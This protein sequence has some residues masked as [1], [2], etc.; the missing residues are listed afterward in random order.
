MEASEALGLVVESPEGLET[1]VEEG[2]KAE[3]GPEAGMWRVE[4]LR[5]SKGQEG[6]VPFGLCIEGD[7]LPFVL[8]GPG[9]VPSHFPGLNP[10]LLLG[11]EIGE[12]W[13]DLPEGMEEFT[14]QAWLPHDGRAVLTDPEGRERSVEWI[15]IPACFYRT[16]IVEAENEAGWWRLSFDPP[17]RPFR[18]TIWE[19]L[20]LFF[21][22][23]EG[24]FP[25][26]C[27]LYTS[28]SPRDR[29]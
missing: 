4:V 17:G 25:Y 23:P 10:P 26:A 7:A 14:L 3:V 2:K 29:G 5:T 13:F 18:L 11:E 24:R 19:G 16:A 8:P 1:T 20:P 9:I 6:P 27:L 28:P 15:T 22:R 12:V 21:E